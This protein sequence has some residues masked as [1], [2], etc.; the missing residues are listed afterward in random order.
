MVSDGELEYFRTPGGHIRI[1]VSGLSRVG[2]RSEK[3]P[4]SALSNKREEVER[5]RLEAQLLKERHELDRLKAEQDA[6]ARA[7]REQEDVE[8][9]RLSVEQEQL[10]IQ[11]KNIALQQAQ[12]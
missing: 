10:R 1:L 2:S 11:R 4:S 7:R 5:L 12:D 9:R 8:R 3:M 6:E